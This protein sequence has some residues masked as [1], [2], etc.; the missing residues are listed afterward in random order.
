VSGQLDRTIVMLKS[1]DSTTFLWQRRRRRL[2]IGAGDATEVFE[3]K[4]EPGFSQD[5]KAR[6]I[7]EY[8][9]FRTGKRGVESL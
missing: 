1:A 6:E 5:F 8:L 9:Q 7:V 3:L 4:P 2:V